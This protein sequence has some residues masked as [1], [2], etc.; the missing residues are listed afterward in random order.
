VLERTQL[1]LPTPPDTFLFLSSFSLYPYLQDKVTI[2]SLLHFR[3]ALAFIDAEYPFSFAFGLAK[4]R[5]DCVESAQRLFTQLASDEETMTF[6]VLAPLVFT[7]GETLN[8]EKMRKFCRFLR[9]TKEGTLSRLD[10][11]RSVD[12]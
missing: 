4:T 2:A 8:K 1:I 11:L 12:K 9:P 6:D 5:A 7:R 10:F 3:R